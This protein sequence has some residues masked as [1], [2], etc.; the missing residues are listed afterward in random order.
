MFLREFT[1]AAPPE[2][3]TKFDWKG[4]DY[5]R[6]YDRCLACGHWFGVHALDLDDLYSGAYVESTYGDRMAATFERIISLPSEKSDNAGRRQRLLDFAAEQLAPSS[7]PTLLDVGS[8]LGVFPY[9]MKEAGWIC[10][11]LDPDP[12]AC[13]H[14]T[15]R[16]EVSVIN[17]DFLTAGVEQLGTYDVVSLNKVIEHVED[18]CSMLRKAAD[19]TES[20]GFVYVEVP[21]GDG[22]ATAGQGRE[23][24]FV[25]HHHVFS[26]ASLSSTVE[27]SGLH[28]ARVERLVEASGKY[29]L[30]CFAVHHYVREKGQHG[31]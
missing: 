1:Y 5:S 18:P 10:T 24:F 15:E 17:A 13:A 28:V 22:A 25:E 14:I 30:A 4:Q 31:N 12:R 6:G 7:N 29:T 23:E 27:R 26:A 9:A 21:D 11:A 3:E 2:G 19:A 8:G 20:G 16:V